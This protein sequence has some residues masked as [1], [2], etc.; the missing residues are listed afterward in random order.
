MSSLSQY[1][2]KSLAASTIP[3]F[4]KNNFAMWKTKALVFLETMD[5]D[6]LDIVNHGPHVPMYQPMLDNAPAVG[7]K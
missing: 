2:P 4:D 7:L 1:H 5:Y 6:M 3:L